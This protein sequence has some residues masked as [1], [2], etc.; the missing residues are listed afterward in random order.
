MSFFLNSLKDV[1]GSSIS[2]AAAAVL[3]TA[4][5]SEIVSYTELLLPEVA[6]VVGQLHNNI[7]NSSHLLS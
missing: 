5:S 1:H 2:E 4:A 3:A 7:F 6:V